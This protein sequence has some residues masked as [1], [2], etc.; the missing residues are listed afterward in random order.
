MD[1]GLSAESHGKG[2]QQVRVCLH[3]CRRQQ[4]LEV[5]V[6]VPPFDTMHVWRPSYMNGVQDG[7]SLQQDETAETDELAHEFW[8]EYARRGCLPPSATAAG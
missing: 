6:L 4:A 3:A 5:S 8:D 2:C 1:N 7:A